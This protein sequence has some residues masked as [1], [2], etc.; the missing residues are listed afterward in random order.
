MAGY[1][2]LFVGFCGKVA[3]VVKGPEMDTVSAIN[4]MLGIGPLDPQVAAVVFI[5][6]CV[7][8]LIGLAFQVAGDWL[9]LPK[10]CLSP[11]GL[12]AVLPI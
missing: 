11:F 4:A 2:A 12:S 3:A 7:A 10:S 1:P 6:G 8:F 5:A 9:L